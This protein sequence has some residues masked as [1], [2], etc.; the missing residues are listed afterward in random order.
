MANIDSAQASSDPHELF[1]I[2][3]D[4]ARMFRL[5]FGSNASQI[6]RRLRTLAIARLQR[7]TDYHG[8]TLAKRSGRARGTAVTSVTGDAFH[9]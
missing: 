5:I 3:K 7:L 8:V 4:D 1:G 9:V 2:G 6:L